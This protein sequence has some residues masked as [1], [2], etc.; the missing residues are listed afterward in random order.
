MLLVQRAWRVLRGPQDLRVQLDLQGVLETEA[1]M[2]VS[3][4]QMRQ[5]QT[6]PAAALHPSLYLGRRRPRWTGRFPGSQGQSGPPGASGGERSSR[7][8]RSAGPEGPQRVH[9]APRSTW[10]N[11]KIASDKFQR[12]LT[13]IQVLRLKQRFVLRLTPPRVF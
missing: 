9:W 1:T 8:P 13:E 5:I 4:P 6:I 2:S 11:C 12:F 10:N 7:K 3:H